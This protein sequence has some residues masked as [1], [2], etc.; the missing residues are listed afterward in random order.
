M[1]INSTAVKYRNLSSR[2]W[3]IALSNL[4]KTTESRFSFCVLEKPFLQN[5]FQDLRTYIN[6]MIKNEVMD[7]LTGVPC[8]EN[9]CHTMVYVRGGNEDNRY[10]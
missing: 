9:N 7:A 1:L 2:L 8:F 5:T 4:M 6:G 10:F 3:V